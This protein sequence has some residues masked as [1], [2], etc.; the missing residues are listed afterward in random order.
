MDKLTGGKLI[1]KGS[2][3]CV[4]SPEIP[5]QRNEGMGTRDPGTRDPGTQEDRVSKIFF[6]RD[7][8]N[9]VKQEYSM[10]QLIQQIP[11]HRDW[12]I[13]WDSMCRPPVF[14]QI[15]QYDETIQDCIYS[16]DKSESEFDKVR[17]MLRGPRGGIPLEHHILKQAT[18]SKLSHSSKFQEFFL[19]LMKMMEPLFLGLTEMYDH[20][21]CHNDIKFDNIMIDQ[22]RCKY[23][24]FGISTELSDTNFFKTRS[25]V[26]F[27]NDRIYLC[28]P[29]EFIYMY[30]TT[31]V[32]HNELNY[33]MMG[34]HREDHEIYLGIHETIFD[35]HNTNQQVQDLIKLCMKQDIVKHKQSIFSMMDTYSLGML[36]PIVLYQLFSYYTLFPKLKQM[37]SLAKIQP[38]IELFK[39]MTEPNHS[40][41]L[42]PHQ[43]RER[44]EELKQIYL[45][46]IREPRQRKRTTKRTTKRSQSKRSQSKRSQSKRSQSKRRSGKRRIPTH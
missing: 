12:A 37:I 46:D 18:K 23:I 36:I 22:G 15:L 41:R 45:S 25:M 2:Y 4:F 3:G 10:N 32:L 34:T 27:G 28:Y 44:Y 24:D 38:F 17:Q 29:Y 39:Q 11:N 14:E 35:R 20:K 13:T 7:S 21:I 5:C 30:A 40:L 8:V 16:T 31:D 9:K 19:R 6:H 33:M 43:V 26:E 42:H 1:G